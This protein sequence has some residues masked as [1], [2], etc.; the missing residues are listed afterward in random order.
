[1]A[2]DPIKA[3]EAGQPLTGL[4][5]VV[6]QVVWAVNLLLKMEVRRGTSDRLHVDKGVIVLELVPG[7]GTAATMSAVTLYPWQPYSSPYL[8]EGDPPDDQERR[9]RIRPCWVYDGS[10]VW[11]PARRNIEIIVPPNCSD[12]YFVW[13]VADVAADGSITALDYDHGA[14]PPPRAPAGN[15]TT[16]APP[17][18]AYFCLFF[19]TSTATAIDDVSNVFAWTPLQLEMATYQASLTTKEGRLRWTPTPPRFEPPVSQ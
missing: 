14:N 7:G 2:L 15:T 17:P 16:G 9:I 4:W 11:F 6:A 10:R 1:M 18:K 13:L 12:G 5:K 19:V 3:P 8:G